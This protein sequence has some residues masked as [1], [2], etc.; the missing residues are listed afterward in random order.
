MQQWL[1]SN[2]SYTSMQGNNAPH[3]IGFRGSKS[4]MRVLTTADSSEKLIVNLRLT[5]AHAQLLKETPG[6]ADTFLEARAAAARPS[7]R[8]TVNF[9]PPHS[10]PGPQPLFALQR[11][12]R[13]RRDVLFHCRQQVPRVCVR[14]V[15]NEL[16]CV[17][18]R[19]QRAAACA[20]VAPLRQPEGLSVSLQP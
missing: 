20:A 4:M 19:R 6:G 12:L 10:R 5:K 17:T 13:A 9:S 18:V 7:L 16:L 2:F 8:L 11:I 14:S 15:L 1:R 3:D